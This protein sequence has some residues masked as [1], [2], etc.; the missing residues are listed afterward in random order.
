MD[1]FVLL[2][3]AHTP[4]NDERGFAFN[5][6]ACNNTTSPSLRERSNPY[7]QNN[8][9]AHN[10]KGYSIFFCYCQFWIAAPFS[11]AR[12]DRGKLSLRGACGE[13]IQ[14]TPP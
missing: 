13:A 2:R 10:K 4:R 1:C 14:K 5:T 7:K 9:N 12:N 11:T 3:F 8:L 6:A